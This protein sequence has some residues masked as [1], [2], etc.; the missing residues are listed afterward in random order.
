MDAVILAAGAGTRLRPLTL[1][2]PK[3]LVPIGADRT[4]LDHQITALAA[5]G[6]DH[7]RLVVG[8]LSQM[9]REHCGDGSRYGLRIGYVENPNWETTN[10]IYSLF[11]ALDD[12]DQA[13]TYLCNCDILFDARLLQ[14]LAASQGSAIAV[15]AQRDRLP[16]EMNVR[17][18]E[19]QR[20]EAISKQLDPATTQ[21]VS[22][23]IVLLRN[24]DG[25][26]VAGQ[27]RSLV[28]ANALDTFPT[29]AYGPLVEDRRLTGVDM[30]DVPWAEIDSVQEYDDARE[31]CA[32][33]LLSSGNVT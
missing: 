10:S 6:V 16:G 20:V 17:L 13:G 22:A 21:A 24:G 7:I 9:V 11:L 1:S 5:V 3:C 27:V 4:L 31:Q 8:Y 15:D 30:A 19:H 18:D 32:P 14:R 28:E 33:Q 2:R 29:A 25:Q 12:W 23:Q 26:Q